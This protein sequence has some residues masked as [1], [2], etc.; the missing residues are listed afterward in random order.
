MNYSKRFKPCLSKAGDPQGASLHLRP[1]AR[2]RELLFANMFKPWYVTN[3]R[4]RGVAKGEWLMV[5]QAG[6][7]EEVE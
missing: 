4:L 7:R 2:R 3:E 5:A 6:T 1:I